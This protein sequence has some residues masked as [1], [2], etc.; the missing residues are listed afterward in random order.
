MDI[1][2]CKI[3][4]E[5]AF[6]RETGKRRVGRPRKTQE[7]KNKRIKEYNAKYWAEHKKEISEKRKKQYR[8]NRTEL[9][10]KHDKWV[11]ENRDYWNAYQKEYRRRKKVKGG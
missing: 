4:I 1:D 8:K 3:L 10:S 5:D 9:L 7:E 11:K 2:A 6:A